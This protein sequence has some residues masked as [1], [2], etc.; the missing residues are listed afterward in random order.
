MWRRVG[1]VEGGT[2]PD[3][4]RLQLSMGCN[5]CLDPA[6]LTGCPTNAYEKL[7]NG[8]VAHHPDECIGCQYCTWN[9]PYSVPVF[10]PD[11]RIVTKCDLCLPRLE[12]GLEPACVGACP[13]HAITVEKVNVAAWRADHTA[14]DAPHLPSSD[15]THLHHPHR[16][17]AERAA[18][19]DRGERLDRAPG[20]PPLAA[21]VAH[22][23][24]ADRGRRERHRRRRRRSTRWPPAW[25]SPRWPAPSPTSAVPGWP[26][27]RCATCAGPGSAAR[28]RCSGST[29]RSP[30][31][32]WSCPVVAPL[33]AAVGAAGVY[34]SARLYIV[35]G[36]PVLGLAPHL[37][38]VRRHRPGGGPAAH[39]PA[40]PGR[41]R[42]GP[43]PRRVRRQPPPPARARG[44]LTRRGTVELTL[45]RFPWR[46]A[47]R[48]ALGVGGVAAALLG[49]PL[50]VAVG[51][52]V[53]GEV[54]GRWLFYVTV[55]PS[56]MPGSFWRGAG[57][58]RD[59]GPRP[60]PAAA[61]PR[62]RRRPVHLRARRAPRSRARVA[63]EPTGG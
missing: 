24:D 6:C 40:R 52:V 30:R 38:P 27:R 49:A 57:H 3:T 31:W 28:W 55:V 15:L 46:T 36:P 10:Q 22:R 50:L 33:A 16:A 13:T 44:D 4:Q 8:V 21:R 23:A 17:A 54:I 1:E 12:D 63:R 9:C 20:G 62:P 41:G 53:A 42:R 35:P 11:R 45:H 59:D 7:D 29:A 37:R 58:A 51:A 43:R 48:V 26:G 61:R 34:A 47:L 19:V 2:F 39:R 14:A 32:R 18:G 60:R 25:P 56:N 5:H